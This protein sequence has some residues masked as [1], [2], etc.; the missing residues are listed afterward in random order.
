MRFRGQVATQDPSTITSGSGGRYIQY[1]GGFMVET[2]TAGLPWGRKMS[3]PYAFRGPGTLVAEKGVYDN[4]V[5]LNDHVFDRAFDGRVHPSDAPVAGDQRTLPI[6]EMAAHTRKERHLP[7]MKGRTEWEAEGGFSL[8]DLTNQL[9]TTT[10]THALY[11]TELHDRLNA[12]EALAN[13]RPLSAT[14]AGNTRAEL[15]RM[16]TLTDAEK[17][18]LTGSVSD[19]STPVHTTR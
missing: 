3:A 13:Q 1:T 9:W 5:R 15:L 8:G 17:A 7:T 14:E 12:L 10:E 16:R 19:R 6:A 11:L 18:L 2:V 4:G